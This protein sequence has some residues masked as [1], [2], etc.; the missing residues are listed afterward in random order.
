[1]A[2]QQLPQT[3]AYRK[4]TEDDLRAEALKYSTKVD[5]IRNSRRAY[6]TAVHR[7]ILDDICEHM[8][9]KLTFWTDEALTAEAKKYRSRWEFQQKSTNA[10]MAAQRRG[11][12]DEICGH[13][14]SRLSAESDS[15]YIWRPKNL[16]FCKVGVTSNHL[17]LLRMFQVA[18]NLG[19]QPELIAMSTTTSDPFKI[20][21]KLLELGVP[22]VFRNR[23]DGHTEFR[24]MGPDDLAQAVNIIASNSW[25][26]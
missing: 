26:N 6:D 24:W 13:M 9:S 7:K 11:L 20:E 3:R 14:P 1:M 12:L 16:A 22:V 19:V 25:L 15:V 17:G 18:D 4:W 10:Y 5:F 21:R 23:F 2:D 8:S